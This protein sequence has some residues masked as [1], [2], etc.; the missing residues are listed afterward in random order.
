LAALVDMI[1]ATNAELAQPATN[2]S[3]AAQSISSPFGRLWMISST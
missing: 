2:R 1:A 3:L